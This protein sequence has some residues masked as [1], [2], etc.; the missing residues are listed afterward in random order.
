MQA[1]AGRVERVID[2]CAARGI[3]HLVFSRREKGTRAIKI[4]VRVSGMQVAG[5][6]RT[7]CLVGR[8]APASLD[9]ARAAIDT[10]AALGAPVLTIVAGGTGPDIKGLA[11]MQ[12][13]VAHQIAALG[14]PRRRPGCQPSPRTIEPDVWPQPD[15]PVHCK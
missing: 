3:G 11:E 10:A 13:R 1:Q 14:P 5:L 15:L 12:K 2:A 9:D 6:C 4:G 8:D 7:P